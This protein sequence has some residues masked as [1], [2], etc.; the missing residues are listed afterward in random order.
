MVKCE[1]ITKIS[2]VILP[3]KTVIPKK[4]VN[5][6]KKFVGKPLID[7]KFINHVILSCGKFKCSNCYTAT[8][9]WYTKKWS[10]L[11]KSLME[12]HNVQ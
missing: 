3:W 6:F 12:N 7:V 4:I 2:T 1:N 8:K 10:H 5:F 11:M 9:N